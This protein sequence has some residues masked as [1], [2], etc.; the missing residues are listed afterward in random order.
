MKLTKNSDINK[1]EYAGYG[2]GFDSKGTFSHPSK[3]TDVNVV[4]FGA[5]MNSSVHTNNNTK[6]I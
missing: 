4:I 2:A 6:S 3:T 1:Y 5:D